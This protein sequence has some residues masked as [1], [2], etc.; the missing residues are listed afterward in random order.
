MQIV[1]FGIMISR[2]PLQHI[3]LYLLLY[4]AIAALAVGC[5]RS[6]DLSSPEKNHETI[7]RA[8]RTKDFDLW[9]KKVWGQIFI[10][11]NADRFSKKRQLYKKCRR[12]K[13]K[14]KD[15]TP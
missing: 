10:L 2:T 11:D 14:D 12:A 3:V 7:I 8:F 15:L 4:S 1:R 6:P 9:L 13:V 5:P